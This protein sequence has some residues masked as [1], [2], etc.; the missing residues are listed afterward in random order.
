VYRV[1]LFGTPGN[2]DDA[3]VVSRIR[4][5]LHGDRV[6]RNVA[7]YFSSILPFLLT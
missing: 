4:F 1:I 5:R 3:F 7:P 2:R 6:N